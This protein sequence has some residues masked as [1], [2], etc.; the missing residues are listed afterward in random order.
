MSV[1][2]I[3]N[4]IH[5]VLLLTGNVIW[6]QTTALNICAFAVL[7][8]FILAFPAYFNCFTLLL[9]KGAVCMH[10]CCILWRGSFFELRSAVRLWF[11]KL[12]IHV[13]ICQRWRVGVGWLLLATA[14][15]PEIS[16]LLKSGALVEVSPNDFLFSSPLGVALNSSRK[17]T[18]G[19]L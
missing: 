12:V 17:L 10:E 14:L 18:V 6:L 2:S 7:F 8:F 3:H 15:S 5:G 13:K 9:P 4:L 11:S 19:L 1:T 16:K